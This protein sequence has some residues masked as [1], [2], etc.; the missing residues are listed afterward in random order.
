MRL[1][2]LGASYSIP[3]AASVFPGLGAVDSVNGNALMEVS[4]GKLADLS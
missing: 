3:N 1:D 2:V 4:D